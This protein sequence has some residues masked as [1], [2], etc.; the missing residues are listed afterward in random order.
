MT[1]RRV[2]VKLVG[3]FVLLCA[4]AV[5]AGEVV[6]GE[7][8]PWIWEQIRADVA[9][10][11]RSSA[12][13]DLA[14][15]LAFYASGFIIPYYLLLFAV[16]LR[17]V[18]NKPENELLSNKSIRA[19]IGLASVGCFLGFMLF[20][21]AEG[22]FLRNLPSQVWNGWLLILG[23]GTSALLFFAGVSGI[24]LEASKTRISVSHS[25]DIFCRCPQCGHEWTFPA[26]R[27]RT[28]NILIERQR[29]RRRR[30]E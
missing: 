16:W 6:R 21:K 5:I 15:Y 7:V 29:P 13:V 12:W 17:Y 27:L 30:P 10:P 26:E 20:L 19:G 22:A 1:D 24:R 3:V 9:R 2:Y 14:L 4:S 18:N 11:D 23:L 28:H 25:A 8:S